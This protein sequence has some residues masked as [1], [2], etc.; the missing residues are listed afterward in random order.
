MPSYA[1][2]SISLA[3][4]IDNLQIQIKTKVSLLVVEPNHGLSSHL[5]SDLLEIP[6]SITQQMS[7]HMQI[8]WE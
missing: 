4:Q 2:P 1:F 6:L 8:P 7:V 5:Y 3:Q